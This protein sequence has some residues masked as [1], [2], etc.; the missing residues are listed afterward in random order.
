MTPEHDV[1][2]SST[3]G[4]SQSTMTTRSMELVVSGFFM[5]V[6]CLVMYDS[7]RVGSGWAS[8]GPRA[9]YFPF[10][11]GLIMFMASAATFLVNLLG[12]TPNLSNFVERSALRLVLKVLAPTVVYLGVMYFLGIYVA[13]ALYIGLFMMWLGKYS[14]AKTVPV[15]LL[16]PLVLF[17]LF[18]IAFLIPLPKGPLEAALG[19]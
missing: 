12:R 3:P 1:M 17:W 11:V 9:G 4:E 18:E 13:S 10:Y 15:A 14:I 7:V 19:F 16:I 8:D 6:A 2:P 5:A